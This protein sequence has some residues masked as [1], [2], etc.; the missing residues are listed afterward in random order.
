MG[1]PVN[2]RELLTLGMIAALPAP[3]LAQQ[4]NAMRRLGVLSVTAADDAIGRTNRFRPMRNDDTRH[5][6]VPKRIID[7]LLPF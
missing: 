3:V 7:G 1:H 6:G 4:P 5:P 2:R